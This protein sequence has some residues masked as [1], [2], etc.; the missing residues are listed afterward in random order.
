[1]SHPSQDPLLP[2]SF[3]NELVPS[4]VRHMPSCSH[5]TQCSICKGYIEIENREN[6]SRRCLPKSRQIE[7]KKEERKAENRV[8]C[9]FCGDEISSAE[10]ERHYEAC[11]KAYRCPN[12]KGFCHIRDKETH[13]ESCPVPHVLTV[14]CRVCGLSL[15]PAELDDHEI[16]HQIAQSPSLP[17]IK[18]KPAITANKPAHNA[19]KQCQFCFLRFPVSEIRNHK[20]IC[21]KSYI[22]PICQ[23]P[24]RISTFELHSRACKPPN[25]HFQG[26]H[27]SCGICN[28]EMPIQCKG[29]CRERGPYDST[30]DGNAQ[31]DQRPPERELAGLQGRGLCVSE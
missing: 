20:G 7:E 27:W 26:D 6:H 17:R 23:R 11:K 30:Q 8:F 24:Q 9:S 4:L 31:W 16:S 21:P 1:M 13:S 25:G 22:C 3:C 14:L 18:P 15:P 28:Q 29:Y 10:L 12:C 19:T 2:C 5:A